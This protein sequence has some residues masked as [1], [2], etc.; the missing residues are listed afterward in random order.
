MQ[1]LELVWCSEWRSQPEIM[2]CACIRLEG[3]RLSTKHGALALPNVFLIGSMGG[4]SCPPGAP[5]DYV[6]YPLISR[7]Y[8]LQGVGNGLPRSRIRGGSS[9][10]GC[11]SGAQDL[12]RASTNSR[13]GSA[14]SRPPG[15][16]RRVKGRTPPPPIYIYIYIYIL[17]C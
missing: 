8:S 2:V 15:G 3:H 14:L 9:M 13:R 16:R 5:Q 12:L 4:F 7:R 17:Y 11:R 1:R 6:G 10:S